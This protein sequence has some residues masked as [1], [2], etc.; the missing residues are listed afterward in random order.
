MPSAYGRPVLHPSSQRYTPG[1]PAGAESAPPE[2]CASGVRCWRYW[3]CVLVLV[4]YAARRVFP[5]L[6]AVLLFQPCGRRQPRAI[7]ISVPGPKQRARIQI[8]SLIEKN[9]DLQC[10]RV[11]V[12]YSTHKHARTV[13]APQLYATIYCL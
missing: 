4:T 10:L 3:C 1:D 7:Y 13:N 8:C 5:R 6:P 11:Q 2:R 12:F 9:L